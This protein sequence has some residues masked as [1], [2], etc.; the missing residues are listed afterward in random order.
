MRTYVDKAIEET[1][2]KEDEL[3]EMMAPRQSCLSMSVVPHV[4]GTVCPN[5]AEG[6]SL[7]RSSISG[8]EVHP[9]ADAAVTKYRRLVCLNYRNPFSHTAG[10]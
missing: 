8:K 2:G 5:G 1:K 4:G 9:S 7:L 10:A 3:W 6:W